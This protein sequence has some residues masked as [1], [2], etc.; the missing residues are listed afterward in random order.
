[1]LFDV[2]INGLKVSARRDE[3]ILTLL[4]RNGLKVPTICHMSG[5]TPTGSCRLCVV[6]IE[7]KSELVTACSHPV[8]EWMKIH[9]HSQRVLKARK[10]LVEL[11]LANHPDDCLYCDRIGPCELHKIAD[12]LNIHERKFRCKK[13]GLLVDR[14]CTSIERDMGKCILCGRCI[15]VCD[16]IMG[17]SAIEFIGR[18][19]K[20]TIGTSLNKG[21]NEKTCI[22]CGQC[23]MVC[24]TNALR[25]K[26]SYQ[27]VIDAL[28][29]P[30]LN[31]VIQYSPTV[32]GSIAEEF[33]LRA[34]KDLNNLLKTAL[35]RMG[36]KLVYD[37]SF[38]ADMN[39]M[40]TTAEFLARV[41]E[42][43]KFPLF[44]SCCPSW[45]R[46]IREM[47]P[48]FQEQMATTKSPQMIIGTLIKSF[49]A[50]RGGLKSESLYTVSVMPCT[51]K[52]DEAH[53]AIVADPDSTPPV[54]QF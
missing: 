25:E 4:N 13:V 21:L 35:R 8:E 7:W 5:F 24:P 18:G 20:C 23:I 14:N 12:E 50:E 33:G 22:K 43:Q 11:L 38:G 16:E 54:T 17:V 53:A 47:R 41:N 2:E 36:F 28:N 49:L 27:E 10:T 52:K 39:I 46:Y 1:M 48:E 29:N 3:T 37:L 45:V 26:M 51:S 31:C 40:E 9:T 42:K 6:E 32:P 30:E 19:S 34:G 44:T 15:R